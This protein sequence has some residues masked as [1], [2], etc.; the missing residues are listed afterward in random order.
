MP[1]LIT[2][3]LAGA[4]VLAGAIG[5]VLLRNPVH[6]ALSLV[7]TLF[8]IAVLFVAQDAQFLAAVQVIVYAGAIVVLFLFVIM[9]LGVDEAEDLSVEPL[10]G[11]RPVAIIAGVAIAGLSLVSLFLAGGATG[12]KGTSGTPV[13]GAE[14]ISELGRLLFTDY[15]FAFEATA[16]LLTI[17]VIGAV[18]LARRP[19][20][21]DEDSA[22]GAAA[23]E[24][25]APADAEVAS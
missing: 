13:G 2:F 5:V 15:A 16:I 22:G 9:L 10:V 12:A 7:G 3:I 1:E 11:Q 17:A 8:G 24:L 23:D 14:N 20:G 18:L 25:G 21:G 6:A 19:P 4:A